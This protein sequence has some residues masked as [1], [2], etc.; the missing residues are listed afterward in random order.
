MLRI[1]DTVDER[2]NDN[3]RFSDARG[4][5]TQ[6]APLQESCDEF[7]AVVDQIDRIQSA[8]QPGDCCHEEGDRLWRARAALTQQILNAAA[9]TMQDLKWKIGVVEFLLSEGELRVVLTPQCLEDCDRAL[10]RETREEECFKTLEPELW[11]ACPRLREQ[12]AE[13]R[14]ALAAEGDLGNSAAHSGSAWWT[15]LRASMTR[16]MRHEARTRVGLRTKGELFLD[17]VEFASLLDGL[18]AL[19]QSYLNDF[20]WLAHHQPLHGEPAFVS[21]RSAN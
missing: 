10:A 8:E 5:E 7:W 16:V 13:L 17:L 1:D 6:P 2:A 18:C 19:Q 21:L 12:I 11:S 3:R 20:K 9:P 4:D 14:G 15:E